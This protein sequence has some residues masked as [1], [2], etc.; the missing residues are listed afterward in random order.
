[1]ED[2]GMDIFSELK[3][4]G[5]KDLDNVDIYKSNEKEEID[6]S[7]V[8]TVGKKKMSTESDF[9]FDKSTVCPICSAT[10][11]EKTVKTGKA[12]IIGHDD[13][14]RPI[15]DSYDLNKYDVTMCTKCGYSSLTKSFTAVSPVMMKLIKSEICSKYKGREEYGEVYTYD[16]AIE[17]YK[18]ALLNAVVKHSKVSE[19]AYLCLKLAWLYRGKAEILPDY[20]H[21]YEKVINECNK[22][23][24]EFLK[25]AYE[26]FV[27][28]LAKENFPMCGM[29]EMTLSYIMGVLAR[30]RKDYSNSMRLLGRVIL[31]RG[32]S[33]NLKERAREQK[34]L[35]DEEMKNEAEAEE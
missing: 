4:Y 15:Y 7:S 31:S 1:M 30:K 19:R 22:F 18:M 14:L 35:L 17:R 13:D 5:F 21:N 20:T 34:K 29:D 11:K 12:R 26:G 28:A 16:D 2:E 6:I 24:D 33:D 32:V 10:F 25:R 27:S 9:I 23:E 3:D 8:A